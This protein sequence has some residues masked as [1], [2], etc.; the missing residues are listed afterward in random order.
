MNLPKTYRE[1][2][3]GN[4][5]GWQVE[6]AYYLEL[7]HT[8]MGQFPA[9][10]AGTERVVITLDQ[11]L[12]EKV[13]LLLPKRRSKVSSGNFIVNHQIGYG[14]PVWENARPRQLFTEAEFDAM[15]ANNPHPFAWAPGLIGDDMSDE[16]FRRML[17]VVADREGVEFLV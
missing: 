12:L 7:D 4:H 10:I 16:E 11:S 15:I 1:L 2:I 8:L 3:R 5:D 13:R 6:I 14:Y 9:L 17:E